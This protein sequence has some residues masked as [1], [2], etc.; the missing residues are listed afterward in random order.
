[1]KRARSNIGR[2]EFQFYLGRFG[3]C[4]S[5]VRA[6]PHCD[7]GLVVVIP[8]YDEPDLILSLEALWGCEPAPCAVEIIVVINS[9][10]G[11]DA[12]VLERNER[13]I[14]EV[15]RWTAAHADDRLRVHSI[16]FPHLPRRQAGVG[17]A[18]K[19]GMDEALRR[20][21]EVG[22]PDGIIA[23]FDADC[24]CDTNYFTALEGHFRKHPNTTGCSVYFEHPLEGS[25][26]SA[27]YETVSNYELHLR[28]YVQALRYA[29]FPF[30]YHTVGSSMAVRASVYLKQGGMNKRQAG[31]DFYFLNKIFPLGHFSELNATR[32][33][34]SPRPSV[35]VPFGTGKAVRAG[36]DGRKAST[37]SVQAFEDLKLFFEEIPCLARG[38]DRN[39]GGLE[40]SR[41]PALASFLSLLNF[42]AVLEE[43]R[44]HTASEGAFIKRFFRW[45]DGFRVLKF[46]HHARDRFYGASEVG[47][48]A[49]ALL[50]RLAVN[51]RSSLEFTNRDLL[52]VYRELDRKGWQGR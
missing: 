27:V 7:L 6:R 47:D 40:A 32:V 42:P 14:D 19:I 9:P 23:G 15:R 28:Y 13:T 35:R 50:E 48:A 36:L 44:N 21:V 37:Y 25:L 31:E 33:I 24:V 22:R 17:L 11:G 49:R 45:F 4:E 34:P 5:Q 30:A 20:L 38:V 3:F 51:E 1:M 8:C 43:I 29:G 46:M 10:L 2:E 16:H 41:S 26:E 52:A 18:R 39:H 12:R